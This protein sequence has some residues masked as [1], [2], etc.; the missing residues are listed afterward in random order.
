MQVVPTV[1]LREEPCRLIGVSRG[2][3]EV[4]D[5]IVL[6]ARP[7][8]FVELLSYRFALRCP[9]SGD[10]RSLERCKRSAVGLEP[11]RTCTGDELSVPGD[12]I[13]SRNTRSGQTADVVDPFKHDRVS[14]TDL[15]QDVPME[16]RERALAGSVAQY[17]VATDPDIED[18]Q[19]DVVSPQAGGQVIWP[20]AVGIDRRTVAV[21]DRVQ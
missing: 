8:P 17:T 9:V 19:V 16:P 14:R 6:A 21:R 4:E 5:R 1:V 7:D 20:R 18:S 13:G 12:E 15:D 3:I 11:V 2:G 10:S